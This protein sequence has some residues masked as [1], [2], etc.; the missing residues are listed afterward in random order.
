MN[1]RVFLVQEPLRMLGGVP[2]PRINYGT[3]KPYGDV[4]FLF[5]WGEVK[6]DDAMDNTAPLIWKLR[7]SLH[8][9]NDFDYIVPLGN[10]ALIGMAIAVAAECNDGRVQILDWMRDAA[11]YRTV[12]VDLN[13]QPS[14]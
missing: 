6:D 7:A 10:P 12:N 9:F 5:Q 11:Q 3:L 1:S 2:V 4:K 14:A 13:C 8:D